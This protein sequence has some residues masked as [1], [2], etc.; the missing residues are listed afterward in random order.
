MDSLNKINY[1]AF[2]ITIKA[3]K[4]CAYKPK[5]TLPTPRFLKKDSYL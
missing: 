4:S 3:G 5:N 1:K 2:T